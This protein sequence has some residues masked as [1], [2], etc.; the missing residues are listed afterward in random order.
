[1]ATAPALT[2]DPRA[3]WSIMIAE[4]VECTDRDMDPLTWDD[5]RTWKPPLIFAAALARAFFLNL[6]FMNASMTTGQTEAALAALREITARLPPRIDDT[7]WPRAEKGMSVLMNLALTADNAV[8]AAESWEDWMR[9]H[10]NYLLADRSTGPG[11]LRRNVPL[12]QTAAEALWRDKRIDDLRALHDATVNAH[13]MQVMALTGGSFMSIIKAMHDIDEYDAAVA[14]LEEGKA[15]GIVPHPVQLSFL[16]FLHPDDLGACT[17]SAVVTVAPNKWGQIWAGDNPPTALQVQLNKDIYA[18]LC[19]DDLPRA[20]ELLQDYVRA[21]T[22]AQTVGVPVQASTIGLFLK[23]FAVRGK[24]SL[25]D[26]CGFSG[27]RDRLDQVV[28]QLQDA[29]RGGH[30]V[31]IW[32]SAVEAYCRQHWVADAVRVARDVVPSKG[33]KMDRKLV[34][35][36]LSVG[37]VA[38]R[39]F[40]KMGVLW[41]LASLGERLIQFPHGPHVQAALEKAGLDRFCPLPDTTCR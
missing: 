41:Y 13:R 34:G 35:T 31:N 9:D 14:V 3:L 5:S 6:A 21:H 24:S 12:L 37:K 20:L 28:K 29:P 38:N 40:G 1:M 22:A 25:L 2:R 7:P 27:D 36:L 33:L 11:Q 15:L 18:V 8:G 17:Y 26:T 16:G 39:P 32:T 19:R 4:V 10:L 23:Y 30:N